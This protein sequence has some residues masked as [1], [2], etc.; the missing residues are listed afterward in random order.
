MP[1]WCEWLSFGKC[2]N[3]CLIWL[4]LTNFLTRKAATDIVKFA[5]IF[6]G[7]TKVARR[8]VFTVVVGPV[9]YQAG[10]SAEE[11][12]NLCILFPL[13]FYFVAGGKQLDLFAGR[14]CDF[15]LCIDFD[16][17]NSAK[18]PVGRVVRKWPRHPP[19]A[20]STQRDHE[21]LP[22]KDQL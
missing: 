2:P 9:N 19:Q 17:R 6:F 20:R 10:R 14:S 11:I 15:A 22:F 13:Q 7:P 8:G 3:G 21:S 12:K 1:P 18:T 4:N 16:T 5:V